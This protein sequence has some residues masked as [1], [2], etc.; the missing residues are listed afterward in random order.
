MCLI[1][2]ALSDGA[3]KMGM[4]RQLA[5]SLAARTMSGTANMI[6][7]ELNKESGAKHVMSFKEEVSSPGGTTIYGISELEKN[8]VRNAFMKCVEAATNRA[9]ELNSKT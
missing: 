3:V 7:N 1:L 4:N 6:I 5:L 9:K 2:D 8:N